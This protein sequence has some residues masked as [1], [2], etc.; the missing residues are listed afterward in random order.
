MRKREVRLN[1]VQLRRHQPEWIAHV[2]S[3]LNRSIIIGENAEQKLMGP[4]LNKDWRIAIWL[5]RLRGPFG[6][7]PGSSKVKVEFFNAKISTD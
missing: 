1:A 5:F 3:S 2:M 6:V 4:D 7:I